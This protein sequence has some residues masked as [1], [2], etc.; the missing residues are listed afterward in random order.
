MSFLGD[1]ARTVGG[2]AAGFVAGGPVGAVI[3]G[4]SQ[5]LGGGGKPAPYGPPPG[6]AG[7]TLQHPIQVASPFGT[8]TPTAILPGGMPFIQ[9]N[10]QQQQ[11]PGGTGG[12]SKGLAAALVLSGQIPAVTNVQQATR[13]VA[14]PGYVIVQTPSGPRAM[15]RELAYALGIKKRPTRGGLSKR[16]L[17]GA[18]R[19][20]AMIK[21]LTTCAPKTKLKTRKRR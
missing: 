15:L 7:P 19:T 10:Q 9:P 13:F 20:Q 3:G 17:Q 14:P 18:Y 5:L 8:V 12:G 4:A 1:L 2:A 6:Y 11:A 16:D 21:R